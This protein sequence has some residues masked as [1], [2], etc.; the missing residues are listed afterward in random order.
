M[1]R[2][3][4][5]V[6]V[7]FELIDDTLMLTQIF[8]EEIREDPESA[9]KMAIQADG[10][11]HPVEFG[12]E[13]VLQAR[14]TDVRTLETMVKHGETIVSRGTCKR[15]RPMN[16]RSSSRRLSRD[17]FQASVAIA[18]FLDV[19]PGLTAEPKGTDS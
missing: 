6:V 1:S 18:A 12:H 15:C 3:T 16:S 11:D 4:G 8:V 19:R 14:W 13:L 9:M 10:H 17:R 5:D 2:A 7:D